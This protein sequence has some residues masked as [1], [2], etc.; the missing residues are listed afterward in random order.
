VTRLQVLYWQD[1]PSVLKATA[2]DG[3]QMSRQLPDW[4]QQE[5]DRVAMA[6]G[7]TG[8]DAYLE[9]W[10]WGEPAERDGAAAR[11][12]DELQR[13]IEADF[14]DRRDVSGP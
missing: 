3:S 8:S 5:I 9:Q 10:H 14:A 13:E 11:L 2:G 7:L 1:I 4:F 6:R 12:L